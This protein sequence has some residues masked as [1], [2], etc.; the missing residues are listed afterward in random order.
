MKKFKIEDYYKSIENV[1]QLNY[2]KEYDYLFKIDVNVNDLDEDTKFFIITERKINSLIF[3]QGKIIHIFD[4]NEIN[5]YF[6]Q[7]EIDYIIERKN[8][9]E[10]FYLLVKYL[11][12]LWSIT[13]NNTYSKEA[14]DLILRNLNSFE[15]FDKKYELLLILKNISD[16]TKYKCE[17]YIKEISILKYYIKTYY[18]YLNYLKLLDSKQVK[19]DVLKNLVFDYEKYLKP[20][21]IGI[22]FFDSDLNLLENLL[23]KAI[24]P[25][26]PFYDLK[27]NLI[28][29]LIKQRNEEDFVTLNLLRKQANYLKLAD[30]ID[31]SNNIL[32]IATQMKFNVELNKRQFVISSENHP[33]LIIYRNYI[34]G[35]SEFLS[36]LSAE[37]IIDYFAKSYDELHYVS[38]EK[39]HTNLLENHY[40]TIYLDINNNTSE[41]Q[42]KSDLSKNIS[43]YYS[44]FFKQI[45][46]QTLYKAI[47]KGNINSYNFFNFFENNWLSKPC[48]YT[49]ANN[50]IEETWLKQLKPSLKH[51]FDL[52]EYKSLFEE[53]DTNTYIL[54][55]DSLTIKFE[56]ILR[57]FIRSLGGS[58]IKLKNEMS[59]MLLEELIEHE[60]I[61]EHFNSNEVEL[62]K[63]VFTKKGLNIRNNVAHSFYKSI[64]YN[65]EKVSLIILCILRLSKYNFNIEEKP[66]F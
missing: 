47:I 43:I 45:F 58:T 23:R 65:F 28:S 62:F 37:Y 19:K 20:N 3:F 61:I 33:Q 57:D 16:K 48:K 17:D 49:R 41:K 14:F 52:F 12:I 8:N 13:S 44:L 9:V 51:F 18:N 21:D 29:H 15:D 22:Y 42:R 64:D 60:I 59:E 40:N 46:E 66:P 6:N 1:N 36:S 38:T 5:N 35:K 30:K 56:G 32:A 7:S 63:Y 2:L 11:M 34:E 54:C 25:L 4:N 39:G 53:S 31:E 26:K 50:E 10:N 24:L 27:A 55:I